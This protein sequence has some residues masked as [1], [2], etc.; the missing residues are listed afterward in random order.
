M[1]TWFTVIIIPI[2]ISL[3]INALTSQNEIIMPSNKIKIMAYKELLNKH[4][5]ELKNKDIGKEILKCRCNQILEISN[6]I[7][8]LCLENMNVDTDLVN[9]LFKLQNQ[10]I[11]L[12]ESDNYDNELIGLK[13]DINTFY[14]KIVNN[15]KKYENDNA[16]YRKGAALLLL[17][18]IIVSTAIY[19]QSIVTGTLK[20]DI[21]TFVIMVTATI[22]SWILE[23]TVIKLLHSIYKK[24]QRRKSV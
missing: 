20:N 3:F 12:I 1:E 4:I 9:K 11:R 6:K 18:N 19:I 8:Q 15:Y 2:L 24:Y 14:D 7:F 23:I 5:A 13:S 16:L 22:T 17:F 21:I 10:C